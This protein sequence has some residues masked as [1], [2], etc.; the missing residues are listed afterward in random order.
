MTDPRPHAILA[1]LQDATSAHDLDRMA[2]LFAPEAVMI[3]SARY[4]VGEQQRR[5]YL[6]VVAE[7]PE[8]LRWDIP[9]F[10]V[11]LETDRVLGFAGVGHIEVTGG[12]DGLR[13][14]FRL[15]LIAEKTDDG[16]RL[17]HFHGSLPDGS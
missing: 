1:R 12:E 15:T 14:P 3:G 9:E 10:D 17:L 13:L 11:F 6:R 5:D 4:N 16:W 7:Q 8:T 2:G